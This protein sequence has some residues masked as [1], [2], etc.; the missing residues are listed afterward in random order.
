MQSHF[1]HRALDCS[2]YDICNNENTPFE[3]KTVIFEGNFQQTLP[4][5]LGCSEEVINASLPHSYLWRDIEILT[6]QTNMHLT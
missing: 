2:L 4:I 3:G 1:T 5:L 6:L